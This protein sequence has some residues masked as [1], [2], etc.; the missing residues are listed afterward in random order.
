MTY[1]NEETEANR[2]LNPSETS[3]QTAETLAEAGSIAP[4]I[5][6]RT[7]ANPKM[8]TPQR[9]YPPAI[10]ILRRPI[11]SDSAPISKV[12]SVATTDE[13]ATINEI[14]VALAANI[15]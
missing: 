8:D 1:R 10:K 11:L 3:E 14:C 12:V 6:A 13:S 5:S 15:L 7:K 4:M 2:L 9:I